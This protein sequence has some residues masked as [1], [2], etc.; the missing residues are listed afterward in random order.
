[1]ETLKAADIVCTS[2]LHALALFSNPKRMI[3]TLRS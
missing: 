1:V 2:A 3:A